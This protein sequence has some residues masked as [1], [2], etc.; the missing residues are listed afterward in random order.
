MALTEN[1]RQELA[2]LESKYGPQSVLDTAPQQKGIL[3]QAGRIARQAGQLTLQALPE[4]GGLAGGM[5]GAAT[6][7][8]P[9]GAEF[10]AAAGRTALASLGR[11]LLGTG[12]G[13]V[14]GTATRQQVDAIMGRPQ[15]LESALAEQLSNAAT[16]VAL[17]AGGNL[18]FNLGGKLYKVAKD[19][20][21]S[22]GLFGKGVAE[23]DLK[24]QVQRLLE[25]EGGS[26][27]KYQ[28]SGG[29]IASLSE[30]IGRTGITGKSVFTRLEDANL[31]A[32]QLKRDEV[33]DSVSSRFVEDLNAGVAYKD[34]I[35]QSQ[36]ALSAAVKPFYE[37]LSAG[38][39]RPGVS[40]AISRMSSDLGLP[41]NTRGIAESARNQLSR[42]EAISKTGDPSLGLGPEVVAELRRLG[43]IKDN[44]SFAEAHD[45]R[46]KLGAR[47]RAIR[48]E[49]GPN[50]PQVAL[51]SKTIS[52][53]QVAMDNAAS[54]LSPALKA[55]YDETSKFYQKGITEL[56]PK[57]LAK[58]NK[59]EAEKLGETI[60]RSGNVSAVNDFYKSLDRAKKLNPN[61][62]TTAVRE[63]IQRGYLSSLI[64]EEATDV[65]VNSLLN[66]GKK[67][68]EDKKFKRTFE[69]AF[70]PATRK[71][72]ELLSNAARLS[73]AR[74]QNKFSL[75]TNAREAEAIGALAQGFLAGVGGAGA[76]MA[77]GG[78]A[79]ASNELGVVGGVLAAGGVLLTPKA[80]AK[81]ATNRKAVND[82]LAAERSFGAIGNLPAEQR[83]QAMIRTA[84]LMNSAYEQAGVTQE[85]LGIVQPQ[86]PSTL[87]PEE[88]AELRQLESRYQ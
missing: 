34:I 73:Q 40:S 47:L 44:I 13:T 39:T 63:A 78:G 29:P 53:I 76:Y 49:F 2:E 25:R 15:P 19:K 50:S 57:T 4:I 21:P 77:A 37:N 65:S 28:V 52:D 38:A 82:L 61:L 46:S 36:D 88:E 58:I 22:F 66:I 33:L 27:T 68:Q 18:L 64:G 69:A 70:D 7:R 79:G 60:F 43:D 54:S 8:T 31:R 16:N 42:A 86:G 84:A 32:L 85:D 62:D 67:L 83:R 71:N 72:I 11:G 87:T 3:Q 9:V 48:D 75:A 30:S 26:L 56:F 55:Q 59:I 10:G 17:D 45:F 12:V 5:L 41:V 81:F 74:P 6:T 14:A 51:L 20:L 23:K 24:A 80:L 35:S 1:E